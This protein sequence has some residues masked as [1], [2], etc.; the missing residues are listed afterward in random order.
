MILRVAILCFVAAVAA[1]LLSKQWAT[2]HA[3]LLVY[4]P[5]PSELPLRL[6]MSLVA[7]GVAVL[8]TRLATRLGLGRQWGVAVGCA[9][10]VAGVLG[11][12]VS[13]LLWSRGVPDFV[14]VGDGWIWNVADFE[15]AVGLS[16]GILSVG[17]SAG[18]AYARERLTRRA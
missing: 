12:G 1:D 9:L 7:I 15:I 5:T 6:L 8:L 3:G 4:N 14:D 16:G 10:L 11:N 17:V 13:A 18:V 2:R